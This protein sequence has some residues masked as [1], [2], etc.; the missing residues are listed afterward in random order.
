MSQ[1][2]LAQ[3]NKTLVLQYQMAVSQFLQGDSGADFCQH[4]A[5]DIQWHLPKSMD[6]LTGA[7]FSGHAGIKEMLANG[8]GTYYQPDSIEVDFRSMMAEG[9]LVHMHF[10]MQAQ[11]KNGK[12]YSNDYQVLYQ[13]SD[14]KIINVWEYFD[15]HHLLELMA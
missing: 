5:D 9:D 6:A 13:I 4:L 3:D 1:A 8:V 14:N 7:L 11:M 2:N 12:H 10:G 15:A